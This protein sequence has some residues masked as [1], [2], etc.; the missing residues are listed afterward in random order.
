LACSVIN[1]T[2]Q[3]GIATAKKGIAVQTG[4]LNIVGDGTIN[5]KNEKIQISIKPEARTG[6][7]INMSQLA[8]LVKVGGT[9]AKPAAKVDASAVLSAGASGAAALA[10][11][12]ASVLVEGLLNRATADVSPCVTALGEQ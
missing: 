5:L 8:G 3:D 1:F 9:L 2:I 6:I 11:G 10:T 4:N 12:G 7:G